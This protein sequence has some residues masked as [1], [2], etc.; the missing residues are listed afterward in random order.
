[1]MKQLL[2][3]WECAS[4]FRW[5]VHIALTLTILSRGTRAAEVWWQFGL[6]AIPRVKRRRTHNGNKSAARMGRVPEC[7]LENRDS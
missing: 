3:T 5:S 2:G 4:A 1:M 6:V 7:G